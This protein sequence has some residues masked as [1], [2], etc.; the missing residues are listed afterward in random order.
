MVKTARFA[1]AC[2]L[3]FH[4]SLTAAQPGAWGDPGSSATPSAETP[5]E[6]AKRTFLEGLA[7]LRAQKWAE[8]EQRFRRSLALAP[9]ESAHYNLGLVLFQQRRFRES[10]VVLEE[11]LASP[12]AAGQARYR[13]FA[14]ALL[15]HVRAQLA[16][17]HLYVQPPEATLRVDREPTGP[18]GARRAIRLDPGMHQL[19]ISAPGFATQRY[20]LTLDPGTEQPRT[21]VLSRTAAGG[22]AS[23]TASGAGTP[24]SAHSPLSPIPNAD[25]PRSTPS[26]VGPWLT[27][28]AGAALLASGL[29]AGIAAKRADDDFVAA[30]PSGRNCPESLRP[31]QDKATRLALVAD[32]LF[33]T[34]GLVTA[35]GITWHLVLPSPSTASGSSPSSVGFVATGRY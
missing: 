35:G 14:Q 3:L 21:I 22:A 16:T 8:A 15:P 11:L 23:G 34:G 18:A 5:E 7:L 24:H 25:R 20:E 30:C 10:Q 13:N 29:A 6:Q 12:A 1:C 17:L 4:T 27:I 31:L 28:G 19:E 2:L 26:R 9:R 33:V 32:V